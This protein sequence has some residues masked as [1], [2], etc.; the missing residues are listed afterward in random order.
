MLRRALP[1]LAFLA[2]AAVPDARA[3]QD[4][5]VVEVVVQ[6]NVAGGPSATLL[7]LSRD[8]ILLLPA[9][10]FLELLA[11]RVSAFLPGRRMDAVLEPGDTAFSFDTE[12]GVYSRGPEGAGL[13]A[14]RAF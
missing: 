7:V 14:R 2:A 10:G 12:R 6:V 5:G 8:S 11:I 4:T 13:D 3:Q 1:L 9:R